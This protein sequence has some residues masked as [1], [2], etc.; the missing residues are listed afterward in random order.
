MPMPAA[1]GAGGSARLL[2]TARP[3]KASGTTVRLSTGAATIPRATAVWP[4][5]MPTATASANE[6]RAVD[7]ASSSRA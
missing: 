1:A 4:L 3:A 5:A 7:S 2:A 6:T